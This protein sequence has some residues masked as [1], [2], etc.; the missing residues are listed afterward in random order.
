MSEF[1]QRIYEIVALIPEGKVL[2]YGQ[3]ARFLG[4]PQ[5]ARMIGWAMHQCPSGLPWH[6]VVKKSGD[7]P[8]HDRS[9]EGISQREMLE[10]EA[11]SFN[12]EGLI[13]MSLYEWEIELPDESV[14][15][16]R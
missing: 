5:S 3:I 2:S 16:I 6:R 10:K 15:I 4:S 8:F 9:I 13:D 14:D 11:V 12:A 7:I 1:Y